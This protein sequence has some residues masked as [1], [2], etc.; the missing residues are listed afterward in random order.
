MTEIQTEQHVLLLREVLRSNY[1]TLFIKNL[2]YCQGSSLSF[3]LFSNLNDLGVQFLC[4][5]DKGLVYALHQQLLSHFGKE[6]NSPLHQLVFE[7]FSINSVK[8][9]KNDPAPESTGGE[10]LASVIVSN[11]LIPKRKIEFCCKSN[12]L[13]EATIGVVAK[14]FEFYINSEKAFEV[15]YKCLRDARKRGRVELIEHYLGKMAE[16][17]KVASYEENVRIL[18]QAEK[19]SK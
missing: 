18:K 4:A 13:I 1:E 11:R 9:D 15:C 17:V 6:K 3:T 5:V 7:K 10:V 12:S 19:R 16:V 2:I 8:I 14:I